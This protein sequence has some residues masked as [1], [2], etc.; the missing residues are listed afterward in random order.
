MSEIAFPFLRRA[1]TALMAIAIPTIA[2]PSTAMAHVKWFSK[3]SLSDKPATIPEVIT[4]LLLA[5]AILTTI[6]LAVVVMIEKRVYAMNWFRSINNWL[7][8]R[9]DS[10]LLVL[11]VTIG[12]TLL[13][14][15]QQDSVFAPELL[16]S[17]WVGWIQFAIA[18]LLLFPRTVPIAGISIL[19]LFAYSIVIFGAFHMVDYLH[20]IGIGWY[21]FVATSNNTAL[22]ESRIP[23]LYITVGFSLAWL[24][25]EKL[26]YPQW[27]LYILQQHPQLTLG[28]EADFF[29]IGAAFVELGLAYLF[30]ICLFER[31]IAALVTL[32]FMT[33]T[34]VFGK[35]EVIGHTAIHGALIVFLLEGPGKFYRPPIAWHRSTA[36]R[37]AFASVNYIVLLVAGLLLYSFTSQHVYE[38]NRKMERDGGGKNTP[39]TVL[40]NQEEHK[41]DAQLQNHD[42]AHTSQY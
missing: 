8:A 29:R 19:L 40:K 32:V 3:F 37:A 30:L 33:T 35:V 20:Y 11:R 31:P 21:L 4:P 18:L 42:H 23:A 5:L 34:T 6:V 14:S 17:P 24:G 13:L 15:W 22:R 36:W 27:S 2:I 39:E 1:I 28:F 38:S 41:H 7:S 16:V 9:S 25:L 26:F 12:A 10:A